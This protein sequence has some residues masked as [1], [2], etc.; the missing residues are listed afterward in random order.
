MAIKFNHIL[1][2]LFVVVATV[3]LRVS[4]AHGG[5]KEAIVGGWN[6]ITNLTNPEVVE[7]GKFAVDE[8]N[9]E[10]KT[11]LKFQEI[12]EGESQVVA[13]INYRLVISAKDSDSPHN[14]LAEVWDKPWEKFRNLTSFVECSL[15]NGEQ[16]C[17]LT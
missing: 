9:K 13:G 2:A 17:M 7:I 10:A 4:D 5:R 12:T 1:G 14:Y 3:L 15:E 8:H 16:Q 6:P 11:K